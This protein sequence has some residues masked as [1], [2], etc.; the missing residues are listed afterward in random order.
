MSYT[1]ELGQMIFGQPYKEHDVPEIMD[2]ALCA[3]RDELQRV[4][5]NLRQA[6]YGDPFGNSANSFRCDAFTVCSYSWDDELGQ[7]YNFKHQKTGTL[8]S[9]YKYLGRGMSS[10][11][12]ITADLAA[13]ILTDC[14]A[15][16]RLIEKGDMRFD[17]PGLYPDGHI[18]SDDE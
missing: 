13:E 8:I 12:K 9:W 10:D 18:V 17:E 5:F 3:I 16:C 4:L 6:Q 11:R 7:P 2:A 15:A 1:P 14:I